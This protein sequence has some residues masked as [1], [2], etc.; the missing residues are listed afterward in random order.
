MGIAITTVSTTADLPLGFIH[1]E[2]ASAAG[3]DADVGERTWI[4]VQMTAGALAEGETVQ[5]A[6]GA[7]T[8]V[9]IQG[10]AVHPSR[11][12]GVGQHA[13]VQDSFGFVLRYGLGEV[14]ADGNVTADSAIEPAASGEVTDAGTTTDG[15]IGVATEMDTGASTL[16]TALVNCQ[17]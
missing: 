3:D 4:Y 12:V 7:T 8:Y 16:V 11:I 2:P 1:C 10:G 9:V 6:A 13:I 14:L 17:G 15:G 5:R